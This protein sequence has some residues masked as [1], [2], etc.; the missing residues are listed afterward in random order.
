MA[1][2]KQTQ[3]A[4]GPTRPVSSAGAKVTVACNLPHGLLLRVFKP[5]KQ[6]VVVGV[7]RTEEIDSFEVE[8]L[9]VHIF[10]TAHEVG[11]A[12]RAPVIAGYALTKGIDKDFWDAWLQANKDSLMVKNKCVM[13]Y[14]RKDDAADAAK[15]NR[16]RVSGLEPFNPDGT[17]PRRPVNR[18]ELSTPVKAVID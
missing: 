5:T 14:E 7:G 12:P 10:G 13:A 15:D 1:V 18:A 9:P 11:K 8:G 6:R 2:E 16:G 3:V 17:D 4:S